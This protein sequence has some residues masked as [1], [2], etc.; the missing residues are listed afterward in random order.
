MPQRTGK[1]LVKGTLILIIGNIIVKILGALF[2]LPLA[3]IVGADGMG[4]YN[5]SFI[6]YDIFLVIATAGFPL[7]I[8]K[9]VSKASALG[10]DSEALK[11]FTVSRNFF[12]IIGLVCTAV[13]LTG[14]KLFSELI[15]NTR[16]YYSILAL[17]PAIVFVSLM[18]A[19]RGY[20]QGTNDMIPTT[21]SQ[22][23]E[24]VCRLVVGLSLS[25]YLKQAGYGIEI[26][27]VGAIVGIT[28]GEFSATFSLGLIHHFKVK[29]KKVKQ[30]CKTSSISIIKTMF[31]TSIPIGFST[32]IISIINMLDNS[33]VMHRLQYIG[34]TEKQSNILYGCF[35]MAFTVFSLPVT[36]VS[37]LTISVFPVLSYAFACKDY[38]R[39][40]KA[41]SASLRMT[42]IAG[43]ASA[44]LFLSLSYPIVQLLYFNQPKDAAVAAPLLMMMGPSAISISLTMLTTCILQSID[45]LI[46][47]SRSMIIG[48]IVCLVLNWFL[49][50]IKS[51]GI[52]AAPVGIFVCYTITAILNILAIR[53]SGQLKISYKD[54]FYKPLLPAVIM[55]FTG[56]I[57]FEA[58]MPSLGLIKASAVSILFCLINFTLVLFLNK[59]IDK[60]DLL[61][62]PKGDAIVRALE[63][64][65]LLPK[66][67]IKI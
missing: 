6:V 52:Y 3:N 58:T 25:W 55:A 27:A 62:L 19:Y 12:L 26:V 30:K 49:V 2:K 37:A 43:T 53:K 10:K 41:A 35:N 20:Y 31:K 28:I 64:L 40:S 59:S 24:A 38:R 18:S 50:G 66:N 44:A 8:S 63:K 48:G 11:I 15:G 4:L 54:L 21:I 13:M 7:A 9:M 61:M 34:Y 47:P 22:I 60:Q 17:A 33:V 16:S 1:N 32:L 29:K 42:M 56:I 67:N 46:L 39:V 45:K 5:A 65:R 14:S 51:I 36:V 23:V 57:S